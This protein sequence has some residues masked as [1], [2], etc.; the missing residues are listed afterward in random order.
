MINKDLKNQIQSTYSQ[1]LAR[2]ELK[3]RPSQKLMIASIA[4]TLGDPETHHICVVEAGTGTGKTLAYL[5]AALPIAITS[6][7][8]LIVSTATINLQQQLI[9]KDLPELQESTDLSFNYQLIKGRGRYLCN[10]KLEEF[11]QG[12]SQQE[13]IFTDGNIKTFT[14]DTLQLYREFETAIYDGK[15]DGDRDQW[16]EV[17]DNE[18]WWPLTSDRHQCVGRNCKHVSNCAFFRARE[19]MEETDCLVANHDIVL[20]DLSLGGGAILPK[21]E[22]CIYIFD[23]AHHLADKTRNHFSSRCRLQSSQNQ[24]NTMEK[25]L[26]K[27]EQDLPKLTSLGQ[28]LEA[29]NSIAD[30]SL[31]ISDIKLLAINYFE[32]HGKEYSNVLR[33]TAGQLPRFLSEA[34][35]QLTPLYKQL[36]KSTTVIHEGLNEG[37]ESAS[38][39]KVLYEHWY[40]IIGQHIGF[41]ES[42]AQL[43]MN[44]YYATT[45]DISFARWIR[46]HENE[47]DIECLASPILPADNLHE[48][49]WNQCSGAVLTSAT[50]SSLGNFEQLA[51]LC[52]IPQDALYQRLPSPFDFAANAL[53]QISK[54][55]DPRDSFTHTQYLIEQ[56]P[57]IVSQDE[58]NLVLFNS[59][60][61]M[62]EVFDGMPKD[63]KR[64]ILLQGTLSK[65]RIIQEHCGRIEQGY[66]STIFGLASFAEGIDLPRDL[67]KHVIIAKIPFAAPDNPIDEALGEW[68]ESQ[69]FN[70]F[71]KVSLP[72]A[73]L[74]LIQATGRLIRTEQDKGIITIFD[75]RLITK[76]YGKQLLNALPPYT[77]KTVDFG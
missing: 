34:S 69:G 54:Q 53:L 50:L 38:S 39:T 72:N 37:K 64:D 67:C 44:Y 57:Q 33:F 10:L 42:Q 58:G 63:W 74:R 45:E 19:A 71:F 12:G 59:E 77:I 8:T 29:R 40:T 46:M 43:W 4:N 1:F 52:G 9:Y 21:P 60:R 28:V 16:H 15:W 73:S 11:L 25:Q 13:M 5:V 66:G 70:A 51:M 41:V 23:E 3:A 49:L 17:I 14:A 65:I 6:G 30:I 35:Q 62:N 2:H 31:K 32:E 18:H 56:L 26:V 55:G 48:S 24:L 20:S 68:V 36:I 61:Q 47:N 22:D 7:K 75:Q 27:L 76:N